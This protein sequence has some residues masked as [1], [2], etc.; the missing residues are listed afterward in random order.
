MK[1]HSIW[2]AVSGED[3]IPCGTCIDAAELVAIAKAAGREAHVEHKAI[4]HN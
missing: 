1:R 2:Y 3:R 4:I